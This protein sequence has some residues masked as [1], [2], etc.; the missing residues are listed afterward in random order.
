M[1]IKRCST[2]SVNAIKLLFL[3]FLFIF[4]S[5]SLHAQKDTLSTKKAGL[6]FNLD[7]RHTYI[8]RK[9]INIWGLRAGISFGKKLHRITLGYYWM[10]YRASPDLIRWPKMFAPR[11]NMASITQTDVQFI[12][13]AYWYPVLKTPKWTLLAPVE[14]GLGKQS[15][16]YK[17][18]FEDIL[19]RKKERYFQPFQIGFY[20]EHRLTPWAGLYAQTGYRNA[21]SKENVKHQFG[22]LYYSYGLTLYPE[23]IF[24]DV[25]KIRLRRSGK[26]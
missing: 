14:F 20:A 12:S 13:L 4:I 2:R 17:D 23:T 10:G 25:K 5:G 9:H 8:N 22:G 16:H 1:T 18:F 11:I 7:S 24:K 26:K 19:M 15:S 3:C 6:L 21:L